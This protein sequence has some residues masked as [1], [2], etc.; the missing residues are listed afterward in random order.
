MQLLTTKREECIGKQMETYCLRFGGS[1]FHTLAF[2]L[3]CILYDKLM[4]E[5]FILICRQM[6][7]IGVF[8]GM[9]SFEDD[10]GCEKMKV[11]EGAL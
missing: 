8:L 5:L 7:V 6:K 9:Y 11:E 1:A 3:L 4:S 10:R 2:T